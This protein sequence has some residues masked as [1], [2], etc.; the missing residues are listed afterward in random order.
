MTMMRADL[1]HL[2]QAKQRELARVVEILH[3]EFA[4]ALALA[5]SAKK[6]Q[7]RILKIVLFG[8][9]ARGDYVD[10]PHTAKGYLSDYDLLIVVNDKRL[11][12]F[13]DYWAKAEDRLI[14]E[15]A[16]KTPVNFIVHTLGEV[17]DA[18]A[19]GQYFFSDILKEGVAL[20]EMKG[21]EPFVTPKPLTPEEA[22]KSARADFAFR[23]PHAQAF[24]K[25]FRLYLSEGDLRHAAFELHQAVEHAYHCA[26]LVLAG[27]SP[28]THNMKFLRALAEEADP[29]LIDAWPRETKRD[30]RRFELLKRAYVEARYSEHYAIA[31]DELQWLGTR[32]AA[33]QQAV[34]A[35]CDDRIADLA[36][37]AS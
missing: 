31:G 34:K 14:V 35:V 29:R 37:A 1:D 19:K 10:E 15:P 8:S 24:M 3:A 4:D 32:A 30:R 11:A 25:G 20:Y 21:S 23:L 6:K 5:T 22:L 26:L 18:L 9:Y 33:L 7:G 16:V 28:S 13:A 36:K 12:D 27:Y 2:P 17:N